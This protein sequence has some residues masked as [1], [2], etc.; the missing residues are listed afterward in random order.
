MKKTPEQLADIKVIIKNERPS[1]K[2]ICSGYRPAFKVKDDYLT[3]GIIK[4]INCDE[5][6][7]SEQAVAKVWFITPEFYPN[8]L[9]GGQVIPFQEGSIVNGYATI[10]KI[11][12]KKLLKI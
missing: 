11:Y 2:T 10:L 7:F 5:I 3:T 8:S 6:N 4:L 1:K 9:E 12:N